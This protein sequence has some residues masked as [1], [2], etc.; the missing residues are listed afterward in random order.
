M[1]ADILL[2]Q[3][4]FWDQIPSSWKKILDQDELHA[5]ERSIGT[6]Y[7]PALNQIFRS[8][9]VPPPKVKVLILGQDPYPR[10]DCAMGFAF[11][12]PAK[13][14]SLTASLRNIFKELFD[15]LKIERTNGD[16][17]DWASQGVLLLNRTLTIGKDGISNHRSSG[18]NLITERIVKYVADNGAIAIL[19]GN[20]AQ[21]MQG[22]FK[23]E[24]VIKSAH[25]SPLSAYRGFFGSKP[26]SKVNDLLIAKSEQPIKW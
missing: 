14:A 1:A 5:V 7:Q 17:S 26:F 24:Q 2:E 25:P 20:D 12:V 18:W 10:N 8:L 22:F 11:S 6:N 3:S 13:S 21:E 15:D 9:V 23:P 4:S 16:L 19:W